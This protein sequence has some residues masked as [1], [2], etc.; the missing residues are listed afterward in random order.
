MKKNVRIKGAIRNVMIATLII[1]ILVLLTNLLF[2]VCNRKAG[3]LMLPCSIITL[4]LTLVLV[5]GA[6]N[7]ITA[8]MI[9][10]ATEY[11]LL[12]KGI[13]GEL[14]VPYCMMDRDGKILWQNKTFTG[15][16]LERGYT[17]KSKKDA[18]VLFPELEAIKVSEPQELW[19]NDTCTLAL[20]VDKK[21]Y[22]AELRKINTDQSFKNSE[23]PGLED[24]GEENFLIA[25]TL[26]DQTEVRRLKRVNLEQRMVS[27]LVYIDNYD[28]ARASVEE[29]R[30]EL[31]IA[32]VERKIT[33]YFGAVDAIVLKVEKDKYFVSFKQK[34][35]NNLQSNKFS[36]L[37]D[38]KSVNV[39]NTMA[40]TVS[41]AIG[42]GG[43]T[44]AQNYEFA[45]TAIDLAL[46]RGGDQAVVK[47]NDNVSFYGGKSKSVEKSTRVKAR[48][49]AHALRELL[50]TKDHVLIMGH[51]IGD[52]DCLGAAIGMY[53]G[54][55]ELGKS[56]Q[57]V[58]NTVT[59][60]LRPVFDRF[61]VA[62]GYS[63]DLFVN[64][65]E[66]LEI[67]DEDTLVIV[68]D[69]N[70]PSYTECPELLE[71]SQ[72][73]VILDHHRQ[74]SGEIIS[75]AA[76]AYIEPSASSAC[77][78]VAEILQYLTNDI[79]LR[80]QEAD[81]LY[82]GIVL[83][84]NQFTN[85][86]GVRTFEAA[87]YIR[88]AGADVI[89]VKK[90]F[91]D[92]ELEYKAKAETVQSADVFGK[93]FIMSVCNPDGLESPTVVASQAANELLNIKDIK[94]SFVLTP[95]QNQIY[96]SARSIDEVNVQLIMERLGGGGHLNM[97]GAQL[98]DMS[99]ADAKVLV[100]DTV[101]MMQKENDI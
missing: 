57:I 16:C 64:S 5:I 25:M 79:K 38:V 82:G 32:L 101:L 42:A 95:Y 93:Y 34:S 71:R 33:M 94:A 100:R 49:K 90:I 12:Q 60:S 6:R 26:Y 73:T 81:A 67:L 21:F 41:I 37:D 39:G 48:V 84:T 63:P 58:I 23:S 88:K 18:T 69:V 98:E 50:L 13:L 72:A 28:E 11:S 74:Q 77:E 52:I 20:S 55:T 10:F 76:L 45:K 85:K 56:A 86:V 91:R 61:S 9:D 31:L 53:R 40:V 24:E 46:G 51:K 75:N 68:V 80:P 19:K 78:M 15:L 2:L 59:S 27:G 1:C 22:L 3:F 54:I 4:I 62:E 17:G 99:L 65:E 83:D 47:N 66:A 96:V 89:R 70:R 92:S 35:L 7:K 87:A 44:Y 8:A 43:D 36:L 30:R 29:V 97:A 14:A